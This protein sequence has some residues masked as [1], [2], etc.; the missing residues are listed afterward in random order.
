MS[1]PKGSRNAGASQ[2]GRCGT[3]SKKRVVCRCCAR[4][5]CI[6]CCKLGRTGTMWRA[7]LS[8]WAICPECVAV[9]S[10]DGP[11]RA[12]LELVALRAWNG[13]PLV[14]V[15]AVSLEGQVW[16]EARLDRCPTIVTRMTG[17]YSGDSTV[18]LTRLFNSLATWFPVIPGLEEQLASREHIE[19]APVGQPLTLVDGYWEWHPKE[20]CE[21]GDC[22]STDERCPYRKK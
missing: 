20:R 14:Y 4:K 18:L 9:A 21:I 1:R 7:P 13:P 6:P 8:R 5:L 17:P 19:H 11:G 16:F 3:P 10:Q 2:C 12:F 22:P 15:C